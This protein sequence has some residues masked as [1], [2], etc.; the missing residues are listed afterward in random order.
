M[1]NFFGGGGGGGGGGVLSTGTGAA[2]AGGGVFDAIWLF[3]S[4]P[5][6]C[7]P[8]E[9]DLLGLLDFFDGADAGL[10]A[11]AGAGAA[12]VIASVGAGC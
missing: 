1:M 7:D 12:E 10:S 4:D 6:F 5:E 9:C 8:A 3:E 2:V 11:G